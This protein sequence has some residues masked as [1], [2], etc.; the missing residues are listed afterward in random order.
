MIAVDTNVLMRILTCD[1]PRQMIAAEL[2]FKNN[3]I[4]LSATVLLETAWV[5][6]KGYRLG[7]SET[8]ALLRR[9]CAFENVA[10]EDE[11][12]FRNALDWVEAGMDFADA[13][14]LARAQ[15]AEAFYTFDQAFARRSRGMGAV[16]VRILEFK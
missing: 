10:V 7:A 3:A 9:I 5:L 12:G 4:W 11:L 2:L 8:V 1:E 14:H 15:D 13:F 16:P 6:Q